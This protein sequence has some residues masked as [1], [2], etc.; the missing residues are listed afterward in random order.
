MFA[1]T[2]VM[3]FLFPLAKTFHEI[4]L[5]HR[6]I[7]DLNPI[8]RSNMKIKDD[9]IIS[10]L[11]LLNKIISKFNL[12]TVHK[13]NNLL[14]VATNYCAEHG[15]ILKR[16]EP[17]SVTLQDSIEVLTRVVT[18][19]ATFIDCVKFIKDLETRNRAGRVCSA[20]FKSFVDPQDKKLKLNCT[21][22]IE[23]V[24]SHFDET[25]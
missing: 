2:V 1:L 17:I 19:E 9:G 12:D 4:R 23:N 18:L 13:E 8:G 20:E 16:Y 15:L 6:N 11:A 7:S 25:N 5:Y 22:F 14:S 10:N 24:N 21:I 3:C